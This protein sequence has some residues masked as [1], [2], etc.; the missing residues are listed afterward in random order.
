[1]SDSAATV[2]G[3]GRTILL[4][5]QVNTETSSTVRVGIQSRAGACRWMYGSSVE[6]ISVGI[7]GI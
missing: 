4:S 2:A 5:P 7:C 3:G 1:M 6:L